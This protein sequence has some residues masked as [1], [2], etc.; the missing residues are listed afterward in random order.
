MQLADR[1]I[2]IAGHA[3]LII[4]DVLGAL[5]SFASSLAGVFMFGAAELE[6]PHA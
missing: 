6:Q 1:D 5:Q 3:P 2:G 4:A